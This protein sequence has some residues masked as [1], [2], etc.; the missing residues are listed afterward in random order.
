MEENN[1]TIVHLDLDTFFVSVERL[2]NPDLIGK[3]VVIGGSSDRGVVSSCSYE[4][5]KFGVHSGMPMRMAKRL[6]PDAINVRG[7]MAEYS[8]YSKMV[9]SIIAEEAP[10]YEKASI[11]EHYLDISG[12]DKFFGC[13][14]W[15]KELR[16]RII[17]ETGLPIS[18]G[19]A[20]NKTVAKIATGEAK[21]N[22]LLYIRPKEVQDFL[23]PLSIRKIPMIGKKSFEL[24][25]NM[26]I[27]NIK[28]LSET[29][30]EILERRLGKYGTGIWKK[31]NGIDNRSVRQYSNRKSI[32]AERTFWSDTND[33]IWLHHKLISLVEKVSFQLRKKQKLASVI[34]V[35]IRYSDF[36]THTLQKQIPYSCFDH[37]LLKE[38]I[39]LF[40][41]L[42][43]KKMPLRLIGFKV[44]GLIK[45]GQ[46]LNIFE[47]THEMTKLYN[48][49]D[50]VKS[51]FG[52]KYLIRAVGVKRN[53][54]NELQIRG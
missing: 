27:T 26:G 30:L 11:D 23:N 25:Q 31:A 37:L 19:I 13:L 20:P 14:Q 24:L 17:K 2:M 50:E 42:Y 39:K 16:H 48:A 12:M 4:T 21:P 9:S 43:N 32:S 45:G 8:K 6:C 33:S 34:T 44:S 54:D 38:A 15:S 3:P 7:N 46:Q 35:K 53:W 5:R 36:S 51:R 41:H 10:I 52:E 28:T 49:V 1:R 40:D 47:D 18:F 29:P 22:G